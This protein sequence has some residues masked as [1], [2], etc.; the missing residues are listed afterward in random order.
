MLFKSLGG[1]LSGSS[2]IVAR[3]TDIHGN[4]TSD[5]MDSD[6]EATAEHSNLK[7]K[8]HADKVHA[9]L[10]EHKESWAAGQ[11]SQFRFSA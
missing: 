4:V 9:A 2:V 11:E 3:Q 5:A 8:K 1:K 7:T 6:L 10:Y